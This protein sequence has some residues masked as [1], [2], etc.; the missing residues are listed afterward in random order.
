MRAAVETSLIIEKDKS[1]MAKNTEIFSNVEVYS[2]RPVSD[3]I[4][5]FR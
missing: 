1:F 5:Q 3:C 2:E 4:C